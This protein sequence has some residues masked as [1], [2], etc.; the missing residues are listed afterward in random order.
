MGRGDLG[1]CLPS[2]DQAP[3]RR[4]HWQPLAPLAPS[5]P[6][7]GSTSGWLLDPDTLQLL[8]AAQPSTNTST[9]GSGPEAESPLQRALR[10]FRSLH[11]LQAPD[12]GGPGCRYLHTRFLNGSC[13]FT[14]KW[15]QQF[16][17]GTCAMGGKRARRQGIH[18]NG[19]GGKRAHAP[20]WVHCTMV[21]LDYWCRPW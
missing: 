1:S 10:V 18:G 17:V 21:K 9:G 3:C 6:T 19:H 14:V 16:K 20:P 5:T 15:A 8:G 7:Q 11:A 4:S 13:A 12:P 2:S